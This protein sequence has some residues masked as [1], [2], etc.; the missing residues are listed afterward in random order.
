MSLLIKLHEE[1]AQELKR[2]LR[3]CRDVK[4]AADVVRTYWDALRAAYMQSLRTQRERDAAAP[5][6]ENSR[7]ISS[8]VSKDGTLK[9]KIVFAV[10]DLFSWIKTF[11]I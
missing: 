4:E 10:S 3:D 6:F 9:V 8:I 7:K 1:H 11:L 2:S 5:L